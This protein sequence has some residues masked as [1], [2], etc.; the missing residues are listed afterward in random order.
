MLNL[1]SCQGLSRLFSL[2]F[3]ALCVTGKQGR[4]FNK[5]DH[6]VIEVEFHAMRVF[7]EVVLSLQSIDRCLVLFNCGDVTI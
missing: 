5:W 3:I 1:T 2:L 4:D 6:K 7:C